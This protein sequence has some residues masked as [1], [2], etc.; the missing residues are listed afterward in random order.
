MGKKRI[1]VIEDDNAMRQVLNLRMRSHNYESLP[2]GDALTPLNQARKQPPDLIILDLGLPGGG[3]LSFLQRMQT[4][5]TLSGIPVIVV[6]AQERS[7]SERPALE[8]GASAF[9][10]KPVNADELLQKIEELIGA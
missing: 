7:I 1:F 4:I 5:P 9:L 10:Q 2:F 6:S 3:G 8:A